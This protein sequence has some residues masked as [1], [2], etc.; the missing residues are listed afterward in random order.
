M[1]DTENEIANRLHS[2]HGKDDMVLSVEFIDSL[3]HMLDTQNEYVRTFKTA[4]EISRSM[5]SESYGVG[6]F[7]VVLDKRYGPANPFSLGCIDFGDNV[8][9]DVYYYPL[10]CRIHNNNN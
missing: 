7:G 2:F 8:N 6:L 9:W 1:C 10:N 4:K 5:N 3:S